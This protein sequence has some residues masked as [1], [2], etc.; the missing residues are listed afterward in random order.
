MH[1]FSPSERVLLAACSLLLG[2][3][4]LAL[5]L[6]VNALFLA[7]VPASGGELREGV[8]GT[9]RFLNPL[10]ALSDADRDLVSLVYSGLLKAT[11][12]GDLIPDL[13]ENY[14]I[15]S[16][17][18]SYS[19][20]LRSD[21]RF[22]DGTRVLADD[23]L[24]TIQKAQDPALKSPKRANWEGVTTEKTDE[25]TVILTL[26]QP[27]APFLENATLGILPRRLWKDADAEQF[28]F[29]P[30]NTQAVGSG[31][32]RIKSIHR[33]S[34][35]LPFLYELVPFAD[36][37]LGTPR[38]AKII[39]RFYS[40]EAGLLVALEK[41]EVESAD[42]IAPEAALRLQEKN[43]RIERARLPRVFAVF[44][45]QNQQPL[46]AEKSV[47]E[48]LLGAADKDAIV[49]RV[50]RGYGAAIDAPLPFLPR[51]AESG[52]ANSTEEIDE[53]RTR[54]LR[55]KWTVGEDGIRRRAKG[56][57]TQRLSF[58]LT[59]SNVPELRETAE[60]LKEMWGH[61]GAEVKV[62]VFEPGDLNQNVI[63]PRKYDALLFGEIVGRDAD[64]FAFWHSSQRNDP[65]LNIALYTNSKT[66]RLL[67]TARR[68]QDEQKRSEANE[69]V[70]AEIVHDLPAVFLY[71]PDFIYVLPERV[72][73][74]A[75]RRLT[76]PSERFL[77]VHEWYINTEKVWGVFAKSNI[78]SD[79]AGQ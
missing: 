29:S 10:L 25:R 68:E 42:T 13:A 62:Q 76:I 8:V 4:A 51:D 61:I 31:P 19:F 67:E 21:A 27:Y 18:R 45:N 49:T 66:D 57:E 69:Q 60:L 9:P 22:H 6:Q 71:S 3:G 55:A 1:S 58:S 36:Y 24:F 34:A 11:P 35:G 73:G 48:A 72:K 32:Y 17:G 40:N 64:L 47:R 56:K 15:S 59:T 74:F 5:T 7:E 26:K 33:N 63:R 12:E 50:L 14:S 23:I 16:D 52:E 37:S 39:F 46:L 75:L 41:G 70:A 53:A 54:L 30:Y 20:V 43:F 77:A 78:T 79:T 38:I 28:P 65:G 44:F 2:L